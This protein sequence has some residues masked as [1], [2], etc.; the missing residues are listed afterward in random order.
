M[1]KT[2]LIQCPSSPVILDM[3]C[4]LLNFK[5]SKTLNDGSTMMFWLFTMRAV[6]SDNP[7][8]PKLKELF[9]RFSGC[10]SSAPSNQNGSGLGSSGSNSVAYATIKRDYIFLE[11][12]KVA[13]EAVLLD[14]F[15]SFDEAA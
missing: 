15:A 14:M 7:S 8:L 6:A 11:F 4:T 1:L 2:L 3:C 9:V 10:L 5:L 12:L 13:K